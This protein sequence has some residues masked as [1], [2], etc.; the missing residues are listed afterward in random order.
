MLSR[1]LSGAA[2]PLP[3][4]LLAQVSGNFMHTMQCLALH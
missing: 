4:V 3:V 2:G 1:W